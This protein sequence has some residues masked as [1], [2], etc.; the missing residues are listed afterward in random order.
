MSDQSGK[1]KLAAFPKGY[2]DELCEGTM[3]LEAWIEEAATLNIDGLEL[4]PEFL[5]GLSLERL[6]KVRELAYAK[7]LEIPMMCT[8]PDFTHPDPAFR[9]QQ[10]HHMQEMIRLMEVLAPEGFR[11]CR[12]LSGQRR[13][14]VGQEEGIRWTVEGIQSLLPVAEKHKVMLV[15]ENHY[16]DGY[17]TRP[18]FAQSSERFLAIIGQIHSDW[19]GINYDPSNALLA[20]EDPIQLLE[21]IKQRVVCM[22]ASDRFLLPGYS[23]DDLLKEQD[24]I[25]YSQMLSHGVIGKGLN[26]YDK[27]FTILKNEGFQ[28]WISI[29]DGVNGIE[30]LRESAEFL[31]EKINVYF[32]S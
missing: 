13:D 4:Y 17:W 32:N 29:E 27:I 26:D 23:M 19:F 3:P 21:Q 8:S 15:M 22:H 1:V 20:G 5:T 12:V 10:V 14:E 16:K 28:G 9:K 11:S 25:G 7:K 31:Q 24:G 18:E 30:E 6:Q 2:M